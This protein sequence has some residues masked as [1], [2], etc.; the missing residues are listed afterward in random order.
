MILR[1]TIKV[2]S[3]LLGD[4]NDRGV[5]RFA[6][7]EQDQN[8]W[9]IPVDE[10]DWLIRNAIQSLR[11]PPEVTADLVWAPAGI[12]LPSIHLY[13]RAKSKSTPWKAGDTGTPVKHE[14]VYANT[15]LTFEFALVEQMSRPPGGAAGDD[16]GPDHGHGVYLRPPTLEE[17]AEILSLVGLQLGI[18]PWGKRFGKGRFRLLKLIDKYESQ[19]PSTDQHPAVGRPAVCD[20]GLTVHSEDAPVH[21]QEDGAGRE[22]SLDP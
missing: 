13:Q 8:Q 9:V 19:Q 16:L 4:R 21:S 10:W 14:A 7:S 1:A 6:R 2:L 17:M 12:T 5:M 18:S 11:L 22:P 3:I 20:S 15:E